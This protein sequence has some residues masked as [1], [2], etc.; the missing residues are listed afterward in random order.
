VALW[1]VSLWKR[2]INQKRHLFRGYIGITKKL[3]MQHSTVNHSKEFVAA[4]GAHTNSIE[5]TWCGLKVLIPK[6]N[7]TRDV[8]DYLWEYVWRKQHRETIWKS[9]IDALREVLYE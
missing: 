6:S 5:A 4:D 3:G 9:F 1:G 7:R 2:N 8:D